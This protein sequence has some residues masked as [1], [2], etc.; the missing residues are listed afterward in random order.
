MAT[1]PKRKLRIITVSAKRW[2]T[3]HM[4]RITFQADWISSLPNGIEGAH[5]K[6]FFA[7]PNQDRAAFREQLDSGP[8]P[9]VRTYTIRH[10]RPGQG[11]M[12]IDFVDHG[13]SG[14]A[15]AFARNCTI[16]AFCAF[17]GPGPVK[18]KDFYADRYLI[19]ADMSALPVASAALE[20]MP[21]DATGTA[22]FEITSEADQQKID[23]P[24]GMEIHWLVH[25]DPH[26]PLEQ[27]LS[28]LAALPEVTDTVQTCI[29]GESAMIKAAREE[30]LVKRNLPK[31]DMY[32]SGYWK[33][34]LIE[35]EH[36]KL[37][38]TEAA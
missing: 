19:I 20:A 12:D 32:I 9:Q 15:S 31:A 27:S 4:I 1:N 28:L 6:L 24:A 3:P 22:Y 30:L 10:I 37:K 38:R 13:E 16:G 34:G 14:P 8:R 29:A 7:E 33:I 36:Q 35:D 17:G 18:L 25:P 23:A 26:Q 5:C 11:E 2:L 21:R